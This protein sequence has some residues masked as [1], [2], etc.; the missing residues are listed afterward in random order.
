MADGDGGDG[1]GESVMETMTMVKEK[2]GMG[3]WLMTMVAF[4]IFSLFFFF[5][6]VKTTRVSI[7]LEL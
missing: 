2:K 6:P 7:R 4:P 3:G 5:L 1:D